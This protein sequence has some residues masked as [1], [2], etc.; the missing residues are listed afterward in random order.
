MHEGRRWSVR[1]VW[2]LT[3]VLLVFALAG[4][5]QS[6]P[7]P[8]AQKPEAAPKV[9]KLNYYF[10]VD[11]S[12]PLAKVMTE[13]VE[14]FNKSHPGIQVTAVYAGN[15]TDAQAKAVAATKAGSPPDVAVLLASATY[16]LEDLGVIEPLDDFIAKDKDG[17]DYIKDFW[18]AFFLNSKDKGKIWAIPFQRSTPVL[19]YNKDA[20]VKAGLDP[21]KPPKT[22]NELVQVAKKLTVRDQSGNVT[23]WGLEVPSYYWI[24]Q[25]FVLS[26]GGQLMNEDGTQVRFND[27]A[28]IEALKFWTDLQD[29]EKVMPK[30]S[31]SWASVATDFTSGRAAMI[32]HS[33]G[34]L[35]GFR[36][37]A[38]F[39]VGVAFV[40]ANKQNGVPTGGGN[41]YIFKGL[42]EERRQAAWTFVRWMTAPEQA[43]RWSIA[44]GYIAVRQ[45]SFD[46]PVM[47]DYVA[48]YPEALVAKDQLKYANKEFATHELSRLWQVINDN[49]AA[50]LMGK[51]TA[52]QALQDAQKDADAIL[53]PFQGK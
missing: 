51:K 27:P 14:D 34:S 42:P 53:K 5:G 6:A 3:L 44:S 8:S 16:Q 43:A 45:S 29:K 19:Y 46:L 48:K 37:T 28:T 9:V 35:V 41:L 36:Q 12:G 38:P 21:E 18:P 15:Y 50:A 31:I 40:P 26:N 47:K 11:A 30:A 7:S 13:M 23:Q 22:W 2:V 25:A 52:E 20:F 33:T 10:P 1:V 39:K 49:L 32:F 24:F 4:C 17:Q